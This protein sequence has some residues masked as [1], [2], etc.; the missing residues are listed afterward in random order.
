VTVNMEEI[1]LDFLKYSFIILASCAFI[2]GYFFLFSGDTIF[3]ADVSHD[4][5]FHVALQK[6]KNYELWVLDMNGPETVGVSI[7]NGSYVPCED[8]FRLMHPEGDYLPN[9]PAFSVKETG[10]YDITVHPMGP[11]TNR[12]AVKQDPGLSLNRIIRNIQN[13]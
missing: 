10:I 1:F 12:I 4:A 5:V 8:T 6:D 7:S 11:G 9:H 2:L 3:S 13:I